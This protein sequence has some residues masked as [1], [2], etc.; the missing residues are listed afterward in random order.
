MCGTQRSTTF[1]HA[2]PVAGEGVRRAG[3]AVAQ[4]QRFTTGGRARRYLTV[5]TAFLLALGWVL[6]HPVKA[7]ADG[8][9]TFSNTT[10]I[11]IPATGSPN[12]MG[13][14]SP[15][16][17][18][19]PVSGMT[20][21]VTNVTVTF[22][23][24]TH[25][26][27]N[28]VDAMVVSPTGANLV[29]LS[30]LGDPNSLRLANNI[31]LTFSDSAASGVPEIVDV[32]SGTFRPTNNNPGAAVDSFPAPAPTPSSQTTLAGAFAGINPN[33]E[34]RLFIVDDTSGEVGSMAG[35]W[36]LTIT[37]EVTA[38][39]TTTT[40][41]SSDATST[42][43]DPVTFT[44]SVRAGATPVTA[45]T[46]QFSS[47]GTNVGAP[48]ALNGSGTAGLTTS[49]LAEGSHLIRA[50]YSGASGLLTSNG[51]ITQRVDNATTVTDTTFCNTGVITVPNVGPASPYPSNIFVTGL[52][53]QITKVTAQVKG[54][55]HQAP[56]D[57]DVLLSGPDSSRNLFLMS[58]SGGQTPVSNVTLDFDDAAAGSLP[59]PLTSGT[60]MPTRTDDQNADTMPAPAPASSGATQLATFNGQSPNGTWSLWVRDDATGD[61]GSISGGWCLTITSAVP[62][63]TALTAS[64]NPSTVGQ[65]VTF[66]ATVASGGNPVSAG[67]VQF[68]DGPTDLGAPVSVNASGVA[69]L[70]TSALTAGSHTIT[71]DYSGTSTLQESS[72]SVDQ[73]VNRVATATVLTSSLNPSN[74]GDPVTFTATVTGGGSPVAS[75]TVQF[76][77]GGSNLGAPIALA[78]DGTATFTTSGL[79]AGTHAIRASFAATATHGASSDDL[80][81]VVDLAASLTT[82]TSSLNPSAFGDPVTFTATVTAAGA[83]VTSGN[84]TFSVDGTDVG[85]VTVS[86]A[87]VAT[88]TTASI[89]GG[90][91]TVAARY[92]GTP[93]LGVSSA[94]LSQVVGQRASSTTVTSSLNPAAFGATV[95]FTATV[96][97]GGAPVTSGTVQFSVGGTPVGLPIAVAADGTAVLTQAGGLEPGTFTMT[98]TYSGTDDIAGS[99]GSVSQVVQGRPTTT[100]LTGP[101]R[102]SLGTEAMF[103]ATVS[104]AG[105]PV[106]AGS[107]VFAVDGVPVGGEV[108]VDGSGQA[109]FTTSD[110][111][112]GDHT[113]T[114]TYS[115]PAGGYHS[116]SGS[117]THRVFVEFAIVGTPYQVA[118]GESLTLQA[119]GSPGATFGWD[120][121]GDGDYSDATGLN[122]TLTWA[123]LEALGIDDG[124]STHQIQLRS[125]S[126]DVGSAL[127]TALTVTN[128]APDSVLTGD[129]TATVGRPFT[130]KVG[131]DDPSSAD[132]AAMFTYTV[133]WGDGSP[134]ETVTGPA[135]PP[136]THTYTTE[137]TFDASF[138]ATDKD[139]GTG[140]GTTVQ[141]VSQRQAAPTPSP[142]PTDDSN[143][144]DD[145]PQ[146]GADANLGLLWAGL[147]FVSVGAVVMVAA[148][149]GRGRRRQG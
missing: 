149:I 72:D 120:L 146:T 24:L 106:S 81:Q 55:T 67:T 58:D 125:T 109:T 9:T 103:T 68:S 19:I 69:T 26:A 90:T 98:A 127:A 88:F 84:V 37:T 104:S 73:V 62:T 63:T 46:V 64:P 65:S 43:G 141:V 36:S 136:V 34:W 11:A 85:T 66:T 101:D 139:G 78:A 122:P 10:S 95:S 137:G 129:L 25:G 86:V 38:V 41:T 20:G 83:P 131:A 13:Q 102:S 30:D 53:G 145:L 45:G 123:Q 134:V 7:F 100:V 114:A 135:D 108:G 32:P 75:G 29:V 76:S 111:S 77:D 118:E 107:V 117:L 1:R 132:M 56:I 105:A 3:N 42:T 5:L 35:G 142:S 116:S 44:A 140:P 70:T 92:L 2:N 133:D 113:V 115:D 54:L 39:A 22:N 94:N 59:N 99:S 130:I 8:P 71:A 52:T 49:A 89:G 148:L 51:T 110:L 147:V 4:A 79:V 121:N 144:D 47:D 31:N 15:Y 91:H 119:T 14:A 138:T 28:D 50:T 23:G 93:A 40:V 57:L 128:T 27:L 112:Y 143:D 74:V 87:G 61:S 18:I 82:L 126:P 60:F 16:P 12:Q 48:V 96:T 21:V 17:S 80:D 33:G 6:G 97:A 124:P